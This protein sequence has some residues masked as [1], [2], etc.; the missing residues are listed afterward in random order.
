[1][2]RGGPPDI[3]VEDGVELSRD[4][5][6]ALCPPDLTDLARFAIRNHD[7]IR[8]VFTGEVAVGFIT[9]QIDKLDESLR[10]LAIGALGLIQVAGAASLGEGRL[11]TF[12]VSIL[13]ACFEGRALNDRSPMRRLG[14][15]LRSDEESTEAPD[16]DGATRAFTTLSTDARTDLLAIL[17][18]VSLFGWHKWRRRHEATTPLRA[19]SMLASIA[20][21]WRETVADHV[22]IAPRGDDTVDLREPTQLLRLANGSMALVLGASGERPAYARRSV[23]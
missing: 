5:L 8:N 12:R 11:S 6:D 9:D 10:A 4:I 17:D 20:A 13:E 23:S 14:R 15:L 18:R 21:A 16:T 3:D 2:L 1:M 19:V 22:V 7:Y